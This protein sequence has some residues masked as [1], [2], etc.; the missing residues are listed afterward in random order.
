M[1]LLRV[2][3][4][5]LSCD[6]VAVDTGWP[7]RRSSNRRC[8]AVRTERGVTRDGAIASAQAD[9]WG[10]SRRVG[11]FEVRCPDHK[12]RRSPTAGVAPGSLRPDPKGG[13][14]AAHPATDPANDH[15][16]TDA[17]GALAPP[18]QGTRPTSSPPGEPSPAV[19]EPPPSGPGIQPGAGGDPRR[20]SSR[21][22]RRHGHRR[23]AGGRK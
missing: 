2:Q 13:A 16:L 23:G 4:W 15:R 19:A 9:G 18:L 21:N 8:G 20:G 7:P 1:A 22:G 11:R 3:L 5:H 10:V 17:G 14:D 6:F 12:G